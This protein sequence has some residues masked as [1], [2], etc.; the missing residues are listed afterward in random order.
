MIIA[1][2]QVRK[3][4]QKKAEEFNP[5]IQLTFAEYQLMPGTALCNT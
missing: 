4:R 1:L 3:E 5:V 2:L